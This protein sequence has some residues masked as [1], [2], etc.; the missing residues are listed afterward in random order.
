MKETKEKSKLSLTIIITFLIIFIVITG[1]VCFTLFKKNNEKESN[2]SKT[3]N[4]ESNLD[5]QS[6]NEIQNLESDEN[7]SNTQQEINFSNAKEALIYL[8]K[9]SYGEVLDSNLIEKEN[10]LAYFKSFDDLKEEQLLYHQWL[11]SYE[12]E[13]TIDNEEF[14][15][16][17]SWECFMYAEEMED[18]NR[19]G[20]R[21]HWFVNKKNGNIIEKDSFELFDYDIKYID[22][23]NF[24]E[25]VFETTR[26]LNE[27][28]NHIIY[29]E[30]GCQINTIKSIENNYPDSEYW[31]ILIKYAT[32]AESGIGDGTNYVKVESNYSQY[33]DQYN[34][35][36]TKINKYNNIVNIKI[37]E[38]H[39]SISTVYAALEDDDN[40]KSG[41][42]KYEEI[43]KH[44]K[45]NNY[46]KME[47]DFE[48][49][50]LEEITYLNSIYATDYHPFA[51]YSTYNDLYYE[52]TGM[53]IMNGN[54]TS[55]ED[56]ENNARAKKIKVTINNEATYT[57]DLEDKMDVQLIDLNY[58]QNTI[59]KPINIDVEV[60][61]TYPGK[62]S[63]DVYISDIQFGL[64]S[65]CPGGR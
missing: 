24:E 1:I 11:I 48:D 8:C 35:V 19:I 17:T 49:L 55:K 57:Y 9:D 18:S 10:F 60:L 30:Y 44:A 25:I 16:F 59:E 56:W 39:E 15:V 6:T 45:E 23:P 32:Q 46:K 26:E 41:I 14:Y 36:N 20:Q 43:K 31:D 7:A 22:C 63:N 52:L 4:T 40:S 54:N 65:N 2:N 37:A 53:L 62:L 50:T 12:G 5:T 21:G 58:K 27:N 38:L 47:K 42:S 61:E 28:K 34:I 33:E 13:T 3:E 51:F 64:N 29:N